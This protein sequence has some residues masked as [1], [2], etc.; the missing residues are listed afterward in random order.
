MYIQTHIS[1]FYTFP[2]LYNTACT[3]HDI[4]RKMDTDA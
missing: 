1:K 4:M 3:N 2:G